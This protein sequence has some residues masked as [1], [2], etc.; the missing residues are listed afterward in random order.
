M[1]N[2]RELIIERCVSM[3]K[4]HSKLVDFTE[5][6]R[7]VSWI[8]ENVM[9]IKTI[10]DER[11]LVMANDVELQKIERFIKIK[12][13]TRILQGLVPNKVTDDYLLTLCKICGGLDYGYYVATFATIADAANL[14][15]RMSSQELES[16]YLY[17]RLK[18][19]EMREFHNLVVECKKLAS[20]IIGPAEEK[21]REL[22]NQNPIHRSTTITTTT[23]ATTGMGGMSGWEEEDDEDDD[24][25]KT[26]STLFSM[27]EKETL[28]QLRL[29]YKYLVS[30]ANGEWIVKSEAERAYLE[31]VATCSIETTVRVTGAAGATSAVGV[32]GS[33]ETTGRAAPDPMQVFRDE[34]IRSRQI[35]A[36]NHL[37]QVEGLIRKELPTQDRIYY[38]VSE[39]SSNYLRQ[40]LTRKLAPWFVVRSSDKKEIEITVVD[41]FSLQ[42]QTPFPVSANSSSSQEKGAPQKRKVQKIRVASLYDEVMQGRQA[43]GMEHLKQVQVVMRE[44]LPHHDYCNYYIEI[45]HVRKFLHSKL[46]PWFQ[47]KEK[48]CN[49][50]IAIGKGRPAPL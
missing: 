9:D 10:S 38:A 22:M 44:H 50:I 39:N 5:V 29:L 46:D 30:Y 24:N 4:M 8:D 12:I 14:F 23:T 7:M 6:C 3:L 15:P 19:G 49:L 16:A 40:F 28:P 37:K 26:P 20:N 18:Q 13:C 41:S 34:L 1:F 47:V 17:L 48:N 35:E 43:H 2:S 21:L 42:V 27:L 11:V 32:T 31:M 45:E 36:L 33:I 25:P